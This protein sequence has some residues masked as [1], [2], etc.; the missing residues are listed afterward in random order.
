MTA[1]TRIVV[2]GGAGFIGSHL[3]EALAADGLA[4][5]AIDDLSRGRR[6][7]LPNGFPLEVMRLGD[8]N[9]GERL[10]AFEPQAVVHLAAQV[11][12][13]RSLTDPVFDAQVNVVDTVRLFS[14]AV[15][16]G[17]RRLVFAS[18]AAVYGDPEAIPTPEEAPL[19]P[20]SPYGVAKLAGEGYLG[21][22]AREHGVAGVALRFANVYGP[23]QETVGE[24]GVVAVF[25][26]RLVAGLPVTIHGD[27]R[28]T[29]DFVHVSDVVRACRSA[30][31][32]PGGVYN[33]ATGAETEVRQLFGSLA[34]ELRPGA[35]PTHGP[36]V[37]GEPRRS[38]LATER[39]AKRLGF[40]AEMEFSRGLGETAAWF[41]SS[42]RES[43]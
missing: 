38:A 42:T 21:F 29:R 25:S 7:N 24:A 11:D 1:P 31:E 36:A 14:A 2:T 8:A 12:A 28:Q 3:C 10:R 37:Q 17:A 30:L 26:Q 13:R 41:R 22:F 40:R 34:A 4:V 9:L 33:V 19:A 43:R 23:R 35:T 18:S 32:G 15:A 16:A 5:L 20:L 39:A 27:G 6:E